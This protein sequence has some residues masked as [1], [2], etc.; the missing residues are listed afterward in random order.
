MIINFAS[1]CSG[2]DAPA[3]ALKKLG[4]GYNYIFASEIDKKLYN[5]INI[6]YKPQYIFDNIL[7]R[8]H[9]KL[10]KNIIDLYV[11]GFPC[12]SFSSASAIHE[13]FES[14]RGQIF[15]HVYDTIKHTQ[16]NCFILE[17]V[18]GLITH[19]KGETFKKIKNYLSKLN[20]YTV[21][22]EII[23]SKYF[24]P[25]NRVRIYII[26]VK[27]SFINK[28]YKLNF[29]DYNKT[30]KHIKSII[31]KNITYKDT[32]SNNKKKLLQEVINKKNINTNDY[33][34]IN[35]NT[36]HVNYATALL[37]LSPTILT[38]SQMYYIT[39]LKRFLTI[40]ELQKLQGLQTVN[41]EPFTK[42]EKYKIIGNSITVNVLMYIIKKILL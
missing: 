11:A 20:N 34:I 39:K 10:P 1:D 37:N 33:W 22:Y 9:K 4:I 7:T 3:I 21:Y 32:L 8:N 2:I 41:L 19:D 35:L 17:N 28:K 24:T 31:D 18:K 27:H 6:K 25:Q 5:Y 38:S 36:S 12:P 16:P 26:G 15:F 40:K 29:D 23:N 42:T 13:G 14:D 30:Q